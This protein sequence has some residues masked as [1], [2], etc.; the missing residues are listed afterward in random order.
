MN[1]NPEQAAF[2]A[3][4]L[5]PGI[6]REHSTTLKVIAAVPEGKKDYR[7]DPNSRTAFEL[8]SHLASAD[9]WFLNGIARGEFSHDED[10][11]FGSVAEVVTF[12]ETE[13]PAALAKVKALSADKFAKTIPAFGTFNLP[14]VAYLSFL[15]NHSI[16]H[17]GQLAAYLRPMGS[18]VPQ[19][20]GGSFDEPMEM[21]ASAS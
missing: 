3:Q 17:R 9:V 19:I 12:Y 15:N 11:K 18:K 1:M 2:A 5:L 8:A 7:P 10:R 6:E 20:Y 13:F 21:P 14:A 16:H 4:V